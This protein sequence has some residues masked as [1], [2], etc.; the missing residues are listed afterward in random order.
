[1]SKKNKILNREKAVKTVS[2]LIGKAGSIFKSDKTEANKIVKKAKRVAMK[3]RVKLPS[4]IKRKVCKHC[5]SLLIPGVNCRVR[6]KEGNVVYYCRE[7]RRYSKI[8]YK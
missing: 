8:R 6:T 2:E 3:N 1:M 4:D 5:H 7:C